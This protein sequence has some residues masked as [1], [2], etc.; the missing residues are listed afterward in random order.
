MTLHVVATCGSS[1]NGTSSVVPSLPQEILNFIFEKKLKGEYSLIS[2][3]PAKSAQQQVFLLHMAAD[4]VISTVDKTW[5]ECLKK[6]G[7]RLVVR[8]WKGGSNWWN[9]NRNQDPRVLSC[10]EIVGYEIS[11]Q[12]FEGNESSKVSIPRVLH[13]QSRDALS[14]LHAWAVLEYVGPHSVR[15]D[16]HQL[17]YDA[18]YLEGMVKVRHEFG[19]DEPHPRWGRVPE[20]ESL[21]YATRILN[22]VILPLQSQSS[23]FQ[24]SRNN[25]DDSD[26]NKIEIKTYNT[27]IKLYQ[28][29]WKDMSS[30]INRNSSIRTGPSEAKDEFMVQALKIVEG[31]VTKF[32]PLNYESTFIPPMTPVLVHLDLQP[33]NLLFA[34]NKST[35]TTIIVSS[36]LDWEDAAIADPRF[37]VLLLCRK[38]CSNRSQANHLWELYSDRIQENPGPIRPWLQLE[39]VHSII[40]L[41]LQSMELQNGGRNPWETKHDLWGKL[42]REFHRWNEL[43][44]EAE[45]TSDEA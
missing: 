14:S 37:E 11:H 2:V 44:Q 6:G 43:L 38:V 12:S 8:I 29:S 36:V 25:T 42:Q 19:F 10:S 21:Q 32:L 40:T 26:G 1:A 17:S 16:S 4:T 33:Q 15:F 3:E 18:S 39:T 9:L 30:T 41:L 5:D 28:D 35:D 23:G 45:N 24:L 22:Q 27:M 7:S 13:Y 20:G 31:A 34:K